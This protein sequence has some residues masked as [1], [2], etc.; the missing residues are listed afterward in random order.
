MP[1]AS[2]DLS[3]YIENWAPQ[4]TT[5]AAGTV[6]T[7]A[8]N[9][10][11]ASTVTITEQA[12]IT[13]APSAMPFSTMSSS[14]IMDM[15]SSMADSINNDAMATVSSV[16]ASA[17]SRCNQYY[18]YANWYMQSNAAATATATG[19]VVTMTVSS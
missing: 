18:Y 17:E 13:T 11:A 16:M 3:S 15:Y 14:Q 10:V 12:S 2:P 4:V 7:N 1:Q 19:A 9:Y 6:Y 5:A 8:V